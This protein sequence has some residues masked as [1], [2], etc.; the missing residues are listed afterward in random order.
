MAFTARW[1][2]SLKAQGDKPEEHFDT[3]PDYPGLAIRVSPRGKKTWTFHFTF[4]KRRC[5][6][7]FGHYPAVSLKEARDRALTYRRAL[8]SEP[9][10]DPRSIRA[11]E[12]AAPAGVATVADLIKAY[13]ADLKM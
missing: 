11:G 10:I 2:D 6:M 12:A 7:D 4:A 5:R 8:D 1:L 13:V 9:P 3:H